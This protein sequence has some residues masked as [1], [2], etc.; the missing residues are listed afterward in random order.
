MR[1]SNSPSA[2]AAATILLATLLPT[3]L[4]QEDYFSFDTFRGGNAVQ[5]IPFETWAG[6][7]L[8]GNATS[9]GPI[10]GYDVTKPYKTT[11][12]DWSFTI[13][14]KDDIPYADGD[15]VTG[16]WIFLN[17]PRGLVSKNDSARKDTTDVAYFI[18]QDKTWKLRASIWMLADLRSDAPIVNSNCQGFL[19]DAC[20]TA[21]N[22]E[23][24]IPSSVPPNECLSEFGKSI[25]AHSNGMSRF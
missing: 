6:A 17:A 20:V 18:K 13:Q 19:S 12:A 14:V 5:N 4:A 7:F 8:Q 1:P 25:E 11:P 24:R 10:S 16:T 3:T 2:R 9:I 23:D 22:Q 15:F 21:L